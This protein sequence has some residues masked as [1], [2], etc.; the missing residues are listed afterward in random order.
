MTEWA[1]HPIALLCLAFDFA[2]W[3]CLELAVVLF[4][5]LRQKIELGLQEVDVSCLVFEGLPGF[6]RHSMLT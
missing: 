1:D 6:A 4:A 2:G 5:D 3:S